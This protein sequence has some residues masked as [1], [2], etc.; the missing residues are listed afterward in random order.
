MTIE[1]TS[2]S[3]PGTDTHQQHLKAA[4]HCDAASASHKE[5]AKHVKSGDMTS[6]KA[7]SEKAHEHITKAHEI[8]QLASGA[9]AMNSSNGVK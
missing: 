2:V 3:T 8:S 5:A 4:E 1:H 9:K 7:H 6:A